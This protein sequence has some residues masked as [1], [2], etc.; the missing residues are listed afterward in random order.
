MNSNFFIK[1]R[2]F[3]EQ[4]MNQF[5]III[6][7]RS[8]KEFGMDAI[9]TSVNCPVLNDKQREEV[10]KIYKEDKFKA[11]VVGSKYILSNIK[12]IVGNK[13]LNKKKN[14]L[15]YCWR[16]GQ[17]SLSL[18]LV[19]KSVG[20]NV[21]ILHKGYKGYRNFINNFFNSRV[22]DYNFNILSGLTG[23]GKTFFLKK[24]SKFRPVLNLEEIAKHKGSALG[25]IP[26]KKQPSQKKFESEIW[27]SLFKTDIKKNIWVESESNRIGKLFLPN[28]LFYK[29]TKGK[30]LNLIVPLSQRQQFI[31]S[32]YNY[33]KKNND[34]LEKSIQILKKFLINK[35]YQDLQ[36]SFKDQKF[37]EIVLNLL[38]NHYD[39][40]YSKRTHYKAVNNIV[41][42]DV[43]TIS[44]NG[45]K[46]ILIN[47]ID[48][49]KLKK[50]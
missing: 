45:F 27:F 43:N 22:L 19:L 33:L 2:V 1:K 49:E 38:Q 23:S 10:G 15:I 26:K 32:D 9:P 12:K 11:K 3:N 50:I 5:S 24:L 6:D 31:L 41:N 34:Q 17:R 48:L 28:K 40:I 7:V 13:N 36:N 46:K 20:F 4:T 35:D 30:I 25:D 18:Y 14:I 8:P 37:D 44:A 42:L 16:G 21:E 29:M 47:I 39:K